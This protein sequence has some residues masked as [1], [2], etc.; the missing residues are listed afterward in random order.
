MQRLMVGMLVLFCCTA[1]MAQG[2]LGDILKGSKQEQ[3]PRMANDN[4]EGTIWEYK[5][6]LKTPPKDAKEEVPT[7]EGRFRTQ[8]KAIFDVSKRLPI[9]EKKDVEKVVESI[10]AGKAKEI[11]L[12]PGAQE[13]RL[14]QY[15]SISGGKLR[16]DLDDKDSLNGTMIIWPKKGTDDVWLGTYTEKIAGGKT[17]D[18]TV[19]VRPIE[20]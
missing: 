20:D 7:L 17:R 14:G 3:L 16:L 19:E 4:V 5:G 18:W 1:A 11:K 9:P 15:R 8:N 12:S 13:K 6:T 10:K 2:P